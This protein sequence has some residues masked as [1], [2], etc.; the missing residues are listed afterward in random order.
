MVKKKKY[1]LILLSLGYIFLVSCEK[2]ETVVDLNDKKAILNIIDAESKLQNLNSVAFCV[3]K[4]DSLIWADAIGYANK[5][6]KKAA[7]IDTRYLIASISKAVTAIAVMQLYE[8]SKLDLDADINTYLP[9]QVINPN[10][11]NE[12][13][14]VRMLLNHS[15][16]ISDNHANQFDFYCW[17]VDCDLPLSLYL[18]NFLDKSGSLYSEQTFYTYAPGKEGNY[19]NLGFALLG[20]IVEKISTKP[21]DVYCKQYIFQPLGMSKTEWRIADT[22]KDEWAVLYS[23]SIYNKNRYYSFPDYPDGGLK[24]TVNDFSKFLRMLILKGNFNGSQI[25]KSETIDLMQLPTLSFS[26]GPST[27]EYGLGMFYTSMKGKKLYGHSGGE[28][29][30]STSMYFDP[31]TKVGVIAFTNTT[32]ANL[33]LIIYSLYQ[34]GNQ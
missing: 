1:F 19:T 10:Y 16:S 9:F 3:V 22:P 20:Y 4:N 13:I 6:N 33:D 25:L 18:S 15:S 26:V 32:A 5:E 17:G 2:T 30:T 31:L 34:Y 24:T 12:K 14:T 23:P 29:G 21:F 8:Q 7:G 28:Q 27:L 11:P